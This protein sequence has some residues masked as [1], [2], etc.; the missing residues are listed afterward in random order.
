MGA[1][2]T[3]VEIV[4]LEIADGNFAHFERSITVLVQVIPH[5]LMADKAVV[6]LRRN[7]RD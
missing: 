6:A 7:R 2:R 4:S 5:A 3:V 1:E